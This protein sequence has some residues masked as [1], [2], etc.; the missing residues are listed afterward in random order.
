MNLIYSLKMQMV[1]VSYFKHVCSFTWLYCTQGTSEN[2]EMVGI[3]VIARPWN[4][5]SSLVY[6]DIE[7]HLKGEAL[8]MAL[9]GYFLENSPN[10]RVL[11]VSLDDSLKKGEPVTK[12]TLSLDYDA[13]MKE[14]SDV[15]V[16][17][18][19]FPRLSSSCQIFVC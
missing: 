6:V 4:M 19:S 10:L 16:E 9:V 14:E 5:L 7:R 17:L 13:P 2:P 11:S 12:L 8:E 1:R 15:F 18:L 3:P